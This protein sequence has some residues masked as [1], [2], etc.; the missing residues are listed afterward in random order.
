MT[1]TLVAVIFSGL[2]LI[3]GL[4]LARRYVDAGANHVETQTAE[5]VMERG[6]PLC[7]GRIVLVEQCEWQM[8]KAMLEAVRGKW[9][10]R[11]GFVEEDVFST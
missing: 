9:Q 8:L 7:C 5:A 11:R 3:P 1:A 4:P 2:A 10:T 6:D